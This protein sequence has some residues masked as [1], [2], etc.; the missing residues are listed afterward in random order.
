[1]TEAEWLACT[2]PGQ[3]L[4]FLKGKV[5]DRKLRLFGCACCRRIW[6]LLPCE[7]CKQAVRYAERFA[8]GRASEQERREASRAA[9]EAYVSCAAAAQEALGGTWDPLDCLA[10]E[11]NRQDYEDLYE[12]A[13]AEARQAP[14]DACEAWMARTAAHA[15]Y[16]TIIPSKEPGF[17]A[18]SYH[19]TEAVAF[20]YGEDPWETYCSRS[21][22]DEQAAQ[23]GL[24]AD[25]V[26]SPFHP[27]AVRGDWLTPTVQMLAQAAYEER[28]LEGGELDNVSS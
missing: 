3:M 11:H 1:M 9:A 4:D 12:E 16:G 20:L 23:V 10:E 7:A 19:A 21:D 25:I 5:S 15:V 28:R 6:H 14:T 13:C 27:V 22:P 2:N 18:A 24:L 8:D 26:G 17:F